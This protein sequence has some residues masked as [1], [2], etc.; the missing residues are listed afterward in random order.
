MQAHR[1]APTAAPDGAAPSPFPA[2]LA[3]VRI[4]DGYGVRLSVR[5]GQLVVE[6]GIGRHR[7]ADSYAR[8]TCPF[9]R[10]LILGRSGY[11]SLEAVRWCTDLGVAVVHLDANRNV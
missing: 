3:G 8:A 7:R 2:T 11:L 5:R 9:R 1:S 10:L 4:V 6:D